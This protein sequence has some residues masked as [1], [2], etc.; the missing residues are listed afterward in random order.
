MKYKVLT[1]KT[2]GCWLS[3]NNSI[4]LDENELKQVTIIDDIYISKSDWDKIKKQR[5]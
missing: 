5:K 4:I 1:I 3:L 2:E